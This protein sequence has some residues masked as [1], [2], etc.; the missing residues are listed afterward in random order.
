MKKLIATTLSVIISVGT[1]VPTTFAQNKTYIDYEVES[2][3]YLGNEMGLM[4]GYEDGTFRPENTITRAEFVK[5]LMKAT[6]IAYPNTVPADID[7][8][9]LDKSHWAYDD[10]AKAVT[11]GF[12]SGYEDGTFRPNDNITFEQAVTMIFTVL[13][14]KPVAEL[15]GGYPHAY[16]ALAYYNRYFATNIAERNGVFEMNEAKQKT[17]IT[18]RE[19]LILLSSSLLTPMCVITDYMIAWDGSYEPVYSIG[20]EG[21]TVQTLFS[22]RNNKVSN[23]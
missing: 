11:I 5:S 4:Q 10:I 18:R 6:E 3:A 1:I 13:G 14:Y 20:G 12:V 2:N 21:E 23:E 22:M 17:P 7:F 15:Y 19:S 16:I 8:S 9:D